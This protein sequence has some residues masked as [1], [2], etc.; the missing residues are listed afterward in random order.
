MVKFEVHENG[1]PTTREKLHKAALIKPD[2]DLLLLDRQVSA[3]AAS[4][5]AQ[6]FLGAVP[7]QR[8]ETGAFDIEGRRFDAHSSHEVSDRPAWR[9][10]ARMSR[11]R[12]GQDRSQAD[13]PA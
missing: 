10:E 12:W 11:H 3:M 7:A 6:K 4:F 5:F 8:R 9:K 13:D 2:Y 1:L